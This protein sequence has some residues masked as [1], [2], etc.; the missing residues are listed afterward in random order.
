MM[1]LFITAFGLGMIFNAAPGAVFTE[2]VRQGLIGGYRV[3]LNVQLGSL[4]GDASWA[5]LGL[6][7]AGALFQVPEIRLP[8]SIIGGLYLVYLGIKCIVDKPNI[9]RPGSSPDTHAIK[10]NALF[11]GVSISLTNPQN[12][13]FWAALGSV[14]GGLGV[15]QP[16]TMHYAVFFMGFMTSSV[17]WCF[18]CAAVV[19]VLHRTMSKKLVVGINMLCGVA[20]FYIAYLNAMD[21]GRVIDKA[22]F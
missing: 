17:L 13:L 12:I 8:L 19:H 21:V 14:L 6:A 16:T 11:S 22:Y 7:G 15:E 20:L 4:V 9:E 18:A 5:V 10:N 1:A 3:A 2:T